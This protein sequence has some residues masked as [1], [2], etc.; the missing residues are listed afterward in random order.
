MKW[1]PSPPD[2]LKTF[3]DVAPPPPV[4]RRKMFGY[5]AAFVNGNMFLGLFQ[6][7]MIVR[8]PEQ[9]RED[10]IREGGAVFEPMPGRPM[11]EY[12]VVPPRIL[13]DSKGLSSWVGKA[14]AYG[15]GLPPKAAKEKKKKS[16]ETAR[17]PKAARKADQ[18]RR[19]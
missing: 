18:R 17:T 1:R 3:D 15:R 11:R 19:R 14:L 10:L 4:V 7:Q 5:P 13:G 9:T 2:L 8:L 16:G 6:D 12:V